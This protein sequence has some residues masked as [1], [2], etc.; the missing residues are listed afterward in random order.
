MSLRLRLTL[1]FVGLTAVML[2]VLDVALF[3]VVKQALINGIDNELRL[4]A[5]VLQQSFVEASREPRMRADDSDLPA[6]LDQSA[7]LNSFTT[8]NLFV[9]VYDDAG[10]AIEQSPNLKRQPDFARLLLVDRDSVYASLD[11]NPQQF[12]MDVGVTRLRVLM[13]PLMY[14]N[15]VTNASQVA[16]VIQ[17]VRPIGEIERAM[18]IF[19]YALAFGGVVVLIVAAQG[20]VVLTKVAF[21]P[22]DIIA[23]TA[24][25]IV[26]AAD[27]ERRVPVPSAQDELQRLTLTINDLLDRLQELFNAQRRFL[28]DASHELRT[29]LAAMKGNIDIL[30]RGAAGDKTLLTES[31]H[32][33]RHETDR[34][35]RLVNDLLMLAKNEATESMRLEI[36]DLTS[37]LLEIVRE[38]RPLA[39]QQRVELRLDVNDVVMLNGDRDRLKQA[40]LNL[41]MNALQHTPAD[42][43]VT[44]ALVRSGDVVQVH[45]RDTGVGIAPEDLPHIFERFY[46]ADRSRT[47][48]PHVAST[49]AGLGLAIVKYIVEAHGG[50]VTVDSTVQVGTVFR[51]EL[52]CLPALTFDDE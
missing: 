36:V 2:F 18:E 47:R 11:G 6:F 7:A 9:V 16:G 22:I 24:Q 21:R 19:L 13:V 29:P 40:L 39:Q 46:R 52:P 48:Q 3:F 8:T 38:L 5:Q 45:I 10:N 4:G 28:A 26:S 27:L 32:D 31:L 34:L 44:C 23:Q 25:S 50:S 12:T 17:L 42:G 37:L 1:A 15:T 14:V 33:M 35:I 41:C 20:G 49:G 43:S 51:I 30:Q